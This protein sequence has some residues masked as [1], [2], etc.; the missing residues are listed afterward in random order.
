MASEMGTVEEN[1]SDF[2]EVGLVADLEK[3]ESLVVASDRVG[4]DAIVDAFDNISIV[5]SSRQTRDE[6][7]TRGSNDFASDGK[8]LDASCSLVCT[9]SDIDTMD[10]ECGPLDRSLLTMQDR[11]ISSLIWEGGDRNTVDVRQLTARMGEWH[12]LPD[13]QA[14]LD[15]YDFGAFGNPRVVRQNDI[16]LIT[17]LI[18]RW[19]PETNTFHLPCGE[20]TITLEDIYMILG[21]PV[22]SEHERRDSI[23]MGCILTS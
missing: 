21:L 3:F 8:G 2:G 11:H 13:Q 10:M 16:R 18:E 19:R 9:R 20:M 14:M 1:A 6:K 15:A 22:T 7:E 12:I 17:A 5:E 4:N 23:R